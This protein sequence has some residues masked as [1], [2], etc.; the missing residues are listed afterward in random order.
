MLQVPK[1]GP[2][3]QSARFRTLLRQNGTPTKYNAAFAEYDAWRR[4]FKIGAPAS[5]LRTCV[6]QRCSSGRSVGSA[7]HPRQVQASVGI[8]RMSGYGADRRH[9]KRALRLPRALPLAL[10]RTGRVALSRRATTQQ[11]TITM[12]RHP[13]G[14]REVAFER[15][16]RAVGLV[17]GSMRSRIRQTS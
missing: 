4:W 1:D 9:V 8:G 17:S 11:V 14:T 15:S 10:W 12:L 6:S 5:R 3:W 7:Q 2:C 16:P 13:F